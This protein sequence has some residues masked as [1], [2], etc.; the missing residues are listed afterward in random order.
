[1]IIFMLVFVLCYGIASLDTTKDK[2]V[3]K[4]SIE[5]R[6][7]MEFSDLV[8]NYLKGENL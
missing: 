4:P 5:L 1:M 3:E 2:P 8:S 6:E 7:G